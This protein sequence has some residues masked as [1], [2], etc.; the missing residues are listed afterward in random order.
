MDTKE[1]SVNEA[2]EETAL[3]D[4]TRVQ[5]I[6][7]IKKQMEKQRESENQFL[8]RLLEEEKVI[9][10]L[11][12]SIEE[13]MEQTVE[14]RRYNQEFKSDMERQIYELN[15]ISL[16]TLQ[17]MEER[18][19]A[20]YNGFTFCAFLLSMALIVVSGA[21]HG[22]QSQVSLY[23]LAGTALE[24]ALLTQDK[25]GKVM[26]GLCG[27]LHLFILPM[28]FILFL[29]YELKFAEYDLLLPI[30][31]MINIVLLLIS[32][33]SG[34][35]YN[36]YR[37][38]K[39]KAADARDRIRDIEKIAGK[40]VKRNARRMKKLEHQNRRKE[41]IGR[42]PKWF[43]KTFSGKKKI[44]KE[45]VPSIEENDSAINE[46]ETVA[47]NPM[48]SDPGADNSGVSGMEEAKILKSNDDT[49]T[50]KDGRSDGSDISEC[51]S[52]GRTLPL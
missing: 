17:G 41:K 22:F 39:K 49:A 26:N 30:F 12:A 24:A 47:E 40:E 28:M 3:G 44:T 25:R 43:R 31:S 19:K 32:T 14:R 51:L 35:F 5:K 37:K 20:Y 21:L 2:P 16:D 46:V 27:F 13:G 45:N 52:A 48:V 34:F 50:E 7:W 10:N 38:E 42:I 15:G 23:M 9:Q 18:K 4:N 8:E 36:P 1:L 29:C 11:N 33:L 6:Q